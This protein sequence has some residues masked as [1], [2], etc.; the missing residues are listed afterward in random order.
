MVEGIIHRLASERAIDE[1]LKARD[2][3][4]WAAEMNN[5]KTGT[6]DMEPWQTTSFAQ[7]PARKPCCGQRNSNFQDSSLQNAKFLSFL[8]DL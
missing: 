5:I 3:L 4:R 6:E 7:Y 8:S 2:M 1:E